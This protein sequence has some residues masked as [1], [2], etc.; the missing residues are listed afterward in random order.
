MLIAMI[1]GQHWHTQ[2]YLDAFK[3]AGNE[4]EAVYVRPAG[5]WPA[6]E[7]VKHI[8]SL[9]ELA[10]LNPDLV[11]VLDTPQ[12]ML[13]TTRWLTGQGLPVA[14]E[15][16]VGND[17]TDLL[18]LA[19]FARERGAFVSVAQPHLLNDFWQH[20]P[21]DAGRLSHFR[22]RLINGSPQRYRDWGVPWVLDP[23]V[24]G[25][26]V[27]RNL[28]IHGVS[29]FQKLTGEETEVHSALLSNVLYGL[30]VEEYASLTLRAG[31]AIGH[32]EVGY[33]LGSDQDSEFEMTA[34][35]QT[36][37]IR[38]DGQHLHVLNRLT[39]ERSVVPCL[40]LPRRYEQFAH[41][42]LEALKGRGVQG[43]DLQD[44]ATAMQ[45]I[46]DAY[47]RASWVRP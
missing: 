18:A 47:A 19:A 46:D 32:V 24:A 4:I 17:H 41:A 37:S 22:F 12:G 21:A 5:H 8:H 1:A 11:I 36:V 33:T 16:P 2:M 13:E 25:G 23:H 31:T 29:A 7:P 42:T 9:G 35:W 15:K 40:P 6:G 44:H 45:L 34:H 26:G 14:V 39:G 27:L 38:D 20:V 43:H 3:A 30:D 10:A 28:G